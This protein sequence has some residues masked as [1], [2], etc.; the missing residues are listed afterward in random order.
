MS[1]TALDVAQSVAAGIAASAVEPDLV[2]GRTYVG[3]VM[4]LLVARLLRRP[5]VFHNE[6]FWPDEM[7][8]GGTWPA[9]CW[10]YRAAKRLERAL[11]RRAAGVITLSTHARSLVRALRPRHAPESAVV[12]PSCVD[13]DRFRPTLAHDPLT[14]LSLV[15]AGSLGGRYRIEEMARFVNVARQELPGTRLTVCSHSS[16]DLIRTRL[17]GCGVP[18]EAWSLAFVPYAE[19]GAALRRH[20][21]GL[22][23]LAPGV[24]AQVCSPTKIGEYWASGLPV[25]TTPMVGDVEAAV[26]AEQVGVVIPQDTEAACRAGFRRL[27]ELRQDP[28][29]AARCRRAAER[30]YDLNGGVEIQLELFRRVSAGARPQRLRVGA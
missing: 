1:A 23:F 9:G 27:R 8:D 20:A 6:G 7:V 16:A 25:V 2:V 11:Y 10:R 14:P 26:R 17:R 4:G 5:F 22:F 18:D 30:L 15:Y 3:G 28:N 24:S 19:M 29:L 21:A 13:L 12:V